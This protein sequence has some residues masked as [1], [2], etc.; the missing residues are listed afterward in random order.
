MSLTLALDGSTSFLQAIY[1]PP[2]LLEGSWEIGLVDFHTYNSIPNI[3]ETNNA[4]GI[5]DHVIQMPVGTYEIEELNNF[6][7]SELRILRNSSSETTFIRISGNNNTMKCE[8]ESESLDVDLS[9]ER[10]IAPL[11]GFQ[12]RFL[13]KGRK[14][15]SERSVD[16]VQVNDIRIECNIASGSFVNNKSSHIIYGFYPDVPPGYKLVQRPA[17][18]VYHP[19][20]TNIISDL[21]I[22]ILDQK[23]RL[24]NFRNEHITVRLHLRRRQ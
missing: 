21:Q 19:L 3:D 23:H 20:T 5:G 9:L 12:P 2:I 13:P 14:H 18:V 1:T 8:I 4:I 15:I 22:R 16:I 10:S 7:N 6:I 24:V 11:L 17:T